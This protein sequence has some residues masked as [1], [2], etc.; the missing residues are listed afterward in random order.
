MKRVQP[1]QWWKVNLLLLAVAGTLTGAGWL[2]L[3]EPPSTALQ[4][5]DSPRS[6]LSRPAPPSWTVT[7]TRAS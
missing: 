5:P 7:T 6:A 3:T 4:P 1:E 2:A